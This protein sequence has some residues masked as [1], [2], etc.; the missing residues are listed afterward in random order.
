MNR[1]LILLTALSLAAAPMLAPSLAHAEDKKKPT[2]TYLP[3]RTLT[4][5]I[6]RADGRRGV[7]SA[8]AGL[9][10]PDQALHD[11][12]ASLMPVLRDAFASSVAVFAGA[13]RPGQVPDLDRLD[14]M[15][16]ANT[17]RVLG[18]RG[19]RVLLGTCLV[20]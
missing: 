16:Q 15:L 8:E 10:V 12:A 17:D 11:R 5:N 1:R 18:R 20:N 3:M 13:M 2:G 9:D 14:A 4:A 6:T 19:A 7:F